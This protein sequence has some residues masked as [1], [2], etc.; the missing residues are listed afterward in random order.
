MSSVVSWPWITSSP[1]SASHLD[2]PPALEPHLEP[3]HD[4]AV[5][6][7]RASRA[8]VTLGAR[9]SG[10]V[11]TS[12]VGMF[13]TYG[14]PSA[15][16]DSTPCQRDS[17]SS[18]T[19]RSVPGPR[20]WIASSAHVVQRLRA[21]ADALHVLPPRGDRVV[22]VEPNAELDDLPEPLHVGLAEHLL[23][24]AGVRDAD[25]GPVVQLLVDLP[26]VLLGE[27][28][29]P[30]A[31]DTIAWQVCEQVGLG[32]AG[33]RDDRGALVTDLLRALQ[34]PR[35]RP[36]E[37]VV[38]RALDQRAA[39]VLVAV[40]HVDVARTRLVGCAR[41][42]ARDFGMLDAG[43]HLDELAGLHVRA[44][45]DGQLCVALDPSVTRRAA[46]CPRA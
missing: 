46:R 33:Q 4:P 28:E 21:R 20:K 29:H 35:R 2:D 17:G 25:D 26:A 12:S 18:P 13:A 31:S 3:A 45:V 9:A 24:P 22:H 6:R 11:K 42:R 44:H 34:Q 1:S 41:H 32:V 27:L 37:D 8:D 16:R 14:S 7:Q 30:R 39:D 19:V 43:E 36:R 40:E 10:V 15:V 5:E 38:G 23:R